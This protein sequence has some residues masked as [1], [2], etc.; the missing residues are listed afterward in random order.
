MRTLG[1]LLASLAVA[2]QASA[3]LAAGPATPQQVHIAY[4]ADPTTSMI[5]QYATTAA[6]CT[7]ALVGLPGQAP[8]FKFVGNSTLFDTPVEYFH[9]VE[10]TG[11]QP[12]TRYQCVAR[13]R[14]GSTHASPHLGPHRRAPPA[15]RRYQVGCGQNLSAPFTFETARTDADWATTFAICASWTRASASTATSTAR[16]SSTPPP[17]VLAPGPLFA[18][19]ETWAQRTSARCRS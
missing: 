12:G 13:E 8:A 11:L 14:Q 15:P 9:V 3:P 4:G 16:P 2:A 17:C 10:A 6:A 18:Q 5:L 1:A 7:S 19:T